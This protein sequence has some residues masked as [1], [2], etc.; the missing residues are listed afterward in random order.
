MLE[1]RWQKSNLKTAISVSRQLVGFMR[2]LADIGKALTDLSRAR[3]EMAA[4]KSER[5]ASSS[6]QL[7]GRGPKTAL[8][9]RTEV[10]PMAM[11][12]W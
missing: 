10:A 3:A 11:A 4:L 1:A 9:R 12:R 2:T 6:N 8:P 7:A 5:P